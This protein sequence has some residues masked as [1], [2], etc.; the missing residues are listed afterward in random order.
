M[1]AGELYGVRKGLRASIKNI[2]FSMDGVWRF[3][4][5]YTKGG[6]IE[7]FMELEFRSLQCIHRVFYIVAPCMIQ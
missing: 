4:C 1:I 2:I 3:S 7:V 5:L 6:N